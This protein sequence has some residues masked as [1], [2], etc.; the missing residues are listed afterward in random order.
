MGR[1]FPPPSSP[2]SGGG[3]LKWGRIK[4]GVL[5]PNRGRIKEGG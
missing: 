3:G 1:I 2:S 5:S 4:V